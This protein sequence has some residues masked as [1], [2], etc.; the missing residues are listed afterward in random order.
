MSS[1]RTNQFHGW[2]TYDKDFNPNT[3]DGR[4][5]P[6]F[7]WPSNQYV[8]A[9]WGKE[10]AVSLQRGYMRIIT[11]ALARGT[12]NATPYTNKRLFFQFNPDTITRSVRARNDVQYWMN[13]DP[14]QLTQPAPGDANFAFQ[15]LF[16][17]EAEVA[18]GMVRSTSGGVLPST[19]GMGLDELLSTG[20]VGTVDD[21][22][23]NPSLVGVLTDL[24]QF[25]RI[26]GQGISKEIIDAF[27]NSAKRIREKE[28]EE[29]KS[30]KDSTAE[31]EDKEDPLE[32]IAVDD[33]SSNLSINIGNSAF[34]VANPIRVV[35]SSLFMV[36][37]YVTDTNVVFNK[38]NTA[39]VPTQCVVSVNMQALYIGFAKK[40][41][42]LTKN[43]SELFDKEYPETPETTPEEERNNQGNI[44]LID[45][46]FSKVDD[47]VTNY[48]DND[49]KGGQDLLRGDTDKGRKVTIDIRTAETFRDALRQ[50]LVN[51]VTM[52]ATYTVT[53]KGNSGTAPSNPYEINH[54]WTS[55]ASADM[56]LEA[57]LG[58]RAGRFDY[59]VSSTTL[60][61][62]RPISDISSGFKFD[63]TSTSMYN[64]NIQFVF[65][66]TM[67]DGFSKESKQQIIY[68]RNAS[69]DSDDSDGRNNLSLLP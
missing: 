25:D 58:A 13:M 6:G 28:I 36:E 31:D 14:A 42:Y 53:Y 5:N 52:T 59:P 41:T 34:L 20:S 8:N 32:P 17:R 26:V 51:K 38:F 48:S 23:R 1:Y 55:T 29:Q 54:T 61:F 47:I 16:N 63:D 57:M 60:T 30:K 65:N 35:F 27:V 19:T 33:L 39:M 62:D 44:A 22:L 68:D 12:S 18:S 10:K 7:L 21:I 56:S 9:H 15:L 64:I 50:K 46:M 43:F 66:V 67:S 11:E 4:D 3:R 69:W 45:N 2:A 49:F 37:G 24:N 40:D